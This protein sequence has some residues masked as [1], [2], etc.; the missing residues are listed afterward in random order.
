MYAVASDSLELRSRR[1]GRGCRTKV[2]ASGVLHG[3]PR[4]AVRLSQ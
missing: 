2:F 4:A 1:A 3:E